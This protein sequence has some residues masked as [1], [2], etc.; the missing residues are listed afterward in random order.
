MKAKKKAT[1]SWCSCPEGWWRLLLLQ[2]PPSAS[3]AWP[4]RIHLRGQKPDEA[5]SAAQTRDSTCF[6]RAALANAK[7]IAPGAQRVRL[8]ASAEEG[9]P[10]IAS[11]EYDAAAFIDP[12]FS[13]GG[14]SGHVQAHGF[15]LLRPFKPAALAKNTLDRSRSLAVY[16]RGSWKSVATASL[17]SSSVYTL[18]LRNG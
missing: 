7:K 9:S 5:I 3:L 1:A 14:L 18:K 2:Q 15:E 4:S 6:A 10:G 13:T 12:A 17:A 11:C 8:P 16:E